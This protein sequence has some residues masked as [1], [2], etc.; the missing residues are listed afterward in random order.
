MS[1]I[2]QTW[3]GVTRTCEECKTDGNLFEF[4]FAADG[5]FYLSFFCPTCK[6][7]F[8]WRVFASQLAHDAFCR[9]MVKY[10]SKKKILPV[11]S[12]PIITP[13]N[14]TEDDMKLFR[15]LNITPPKKE[16]D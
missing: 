9:D 11:A 10:N 2:P 16:D 12:P 3:Y 4:A 15:E 1:L 13:E 6:K 5:E 7:P 14:F 8:H